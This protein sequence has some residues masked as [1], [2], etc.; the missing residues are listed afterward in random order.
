MARSFFAEAVSSTL[1]KPFDAWQVLVGSVGSGHGTQQQPMQLQVSLVALTAL[2]QTVAF[3]RSAKQAAEDK[4]AVAESI[5]GVLRGLL[6]AAGTCAGDLAAVLRAAYPYDPKQHEGGGGKKKKKQPRTDNADAR[7][8][9]PEASAL[10]AVVQ[11][12]ET[13]CSGGDNPSSTSAR[14]RAKKSGAARYSV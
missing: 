1:R 2:R 3:V 12:V 14:K 11:L 10:T 4:V 6:Y 5:A 13:V 9:P 8:L 7:N